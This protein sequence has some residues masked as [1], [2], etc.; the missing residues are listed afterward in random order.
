MGGGR[1]ILHSLFN[2]FISVGLHLG[3][4]QMDVSGPLSGQPRQGL[5]AFHQK[6]FRNFISFVMKNWSELWQAG[7]GELS[8]CKGRVWLDVRRV[9]EVLICDTASHASRMCLPSFGSW[10]RIARYSLIGETWLFQQSFIIVHFYT[11]ASSRLEPGNIFGQGWPS[12]S[13]FLSFGN[14]NQEPIWVPNLILSETQVLY[15]FV[16]GLCLW[17]HT[18]TQF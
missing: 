6:Q 15:L 1:D 7:R 10:T 12:Q 16:Y 8:A 18:H 9:L 17:S 11:L 3:L 2:L 4:A 14:D 13:W 5:A